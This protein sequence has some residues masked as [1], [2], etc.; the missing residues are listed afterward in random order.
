MDGMSITRPHRKRSRHYH[1]PDDFHELTFSSYRR[2]PLLTNDDWRKRLSRC[3]N[4]AIEEL[5][6]QLVCPAAN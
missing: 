2:L 3:V 4:Q 5:A 1:Q 6:F